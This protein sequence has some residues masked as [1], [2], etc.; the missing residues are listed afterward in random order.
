MPSVTHDARSFLIDGRRIWLVAGRVPY[1]R[2]PRE[3]WAERIHA[4]K[5]AGFNTIE[6]PVFW[7]RHEPRP[8]KF[9]FQGDND[10]RYFV[11]LVGKAGM[12]CILGIGPY[13]GAGW[14]MGG[15]PS[16]LNDQMGIRLRTTGGP[17]LEAASRFITALTD[18]VRGWQVTAP[19]SGGPIIMVQCESDWTCG[20]D[21]LASTYLGE[22]TR[23]IRESGITVPIINSNQLWAGVEGQIDGWTDTAGSLEQIRQLAVVRPD[24]PR[25]VVDLLAAPMDTWGQPTTGPIQPW[26]ALRRAAEVLAAAGQ[27]TIQSLCAGLNPGFSGGRSSRGTAMFITAASDPHAL[28]SETGQPRGA[29]AAVRRVATFAS[30]FGRVL[31][32]LDPGYRPVSLC[33]QGEEALTAVEGAKKVK[34]A[35]REGVAVM[36]AVGSQGSVVFLFGDEPHGE[37]KPVTQQATLMLS[38]GW[39]LPV[40]L[41][42]EGVAWLLFDVNINGRCKLD[43]TNV[44][45]F[46]AVGPNLVCFGLAGS[47]AMLSVNGS[48]VE[49]DIPSDKPAIVEH[50]GLS[51]IFVSQELVDHVFFQDETVLIGVAGLTPDGTVIPLPGSKQYI[52]VGPNGKSKTVDVLKA[53]APA[54]KTAASAPS[55][56]SWTCATLTDYTDGSSARY[57]KIAGPADLNKLGSPFGYGWYRMSFEAAANRKSRLVFPNAGDRLHMFHDGKAIGVV[58]VGPGAEPEATVPFKKGPQSLV[59][60]AENLGRYYEGVNL[61]ERKGLHGPAYEAAP[62]KVGAPKVVS[63]RPIEALSFRTPLWEVRSGDSTLPDRLTWVVHHKRKTPLIVTIP[64][65]PP[66]ALLVLND[67]PI[68][69]VDRSGP[70]QIVIPFEQLDKGTATLQFALLNSAD[71]EA[72]LQE[73]AEAGIEVREGVECITDGVEMAFAK[74][75]TPAPTQFSPAPKGAKVPNGPIWWRTTFNADKVAGLF[76]EPWGM[77]KGQLYLNGRHVS[78]YWMTTAEGVSVPPQ[79]RY[80]LPGAWLVAGQ[81]ELTL[82]DEHGGNPS[83]CKLAL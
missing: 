43:Y 83:K 50:E 15:L 75:E 12:Y 70:D 2:L 27:F 68:M 72:D 29:F 79:T 36:H 18:Q 67:N 39:T 1:A 40:T 6:T 10:L 28:I 32:N 65:P 30:R 25:Y 9:D 57:A 61:G 73:L 16:W 17:F 4:A 74:W 42:P 41:P 11:D 66:S 13:V 77:T 35:S 76:L 56:G 52:V 71:P 24:Q 7:N 64:K 62:I 23:Y 20:Q 46:G 78:R 82:F 63:G 47:R 80:F 34:G 51:I 55:L 54:E 45:P 22:L 48:P 14:D 21:D 31:A 8:G 44:S 69:Y 49:V 60:L 5:S 3:S 53:K 33:P 19:G 37:G 59:V 81:N 38:D 58:G 26:A